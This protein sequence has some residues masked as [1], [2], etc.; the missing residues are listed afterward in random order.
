MYCPECG[1]NNPDDT[2]ICSG[3][4]YFF[5]ENIAEQIERGEPVSVD[6][7]V[8][9]V[10]VKKAVLIAAGIC[11]AAGAG[12]AGMKAYQSWKAS[13]PSDISYGSISYQLPSAWNEYN[14]QNGWTQY[15]VGETDEVMLSV[16]SDT[17]IFVDYESI[18]EENFYE[19]ACELFNNMT[20]TDTEMEAL[21][22]PAEDMLAYTGETQLE[23]S[24]YTE[25]VKVVIAIDANT[26]TVYIFAAEEPE[27][28]EESHLADVESIV[29]S[30][31]RQTPA[32]II[33]EYTEDGDYTVMAQYDD[34]SSVVLIHGYE[35][36]EKDDGS[37]EVTYM[38]LSTAVESAEEETA[39]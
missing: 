17:D 15:T 22:L 29:Q 30:I 7:E 1:K 28:A 10:N 38:G 11:A 19:Y 31:E 8:K 26:N 27:D 6:E 39:E 36:E 13:Q 2:T 4:G 34:L 25:N 37:I 5:E 33:A 16:T 23:L 18:T 35:A 14:E 9:P 20:G 12:Y 24:E 3:C 32:G 21:E